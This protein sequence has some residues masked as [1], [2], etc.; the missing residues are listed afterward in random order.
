MALTPHRSALIAGILALSFSAAYSQVFTVGE[1]SATADITT[2]FTPTRVPLPTT[3]LTERGRRELIRNLEA[4]QGFAHRALPVSAGITLQ[5]NGQ[6]TPGPAEYRKLIYEKGQSA[7]PGDRVVI[8]SME[9]KGDRIVL[10]FN[11]GPYAK[12]RFLRHI[13][14]NDA[15]VS[16]GDLG[17]T[18]TGSRITLVF[19]GG[20]PEISG[21]EVKAL[22]QPLIDFGVKSSEQ[23]YADTLPPGLKDAIAAHEVL[24]GMNH[25]MVLAALGAPENKLREQ[26]SSDPNGG[27]Y[28]EWIYG[29]VPQTIRFV[30]F[31]G[32][33]VTLVEIAALGKPIEIHNTNEMGDYEPATPTRDVA[34]GDEQPGKE[35][36][37]PTAPPTLR[38]PGEAAPDGGPGKVQFPDK[39]PVKPIP[40]SPSTNPAITGQGT[41]LGTNPGIG[42]GM[43]PGT[44][45]GMGPGTNPQTNPK[46]PMQ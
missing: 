29:H 36:N 34:M 11:G 23:A 46:P 21:P 45:P 1:K 40:A 12:H 4:E 8:T 26:L 24:V 3:K 15:P 25:R 31:V 16:S 19:E 6:L 28:E 41:G 13:Q 7:A 10:D 30:R 9:I 5:A 22:L 38:L 17:D 18:A 14:L 2:D 39:A 33:R 35:A 20:V 32:D 27:R 43:N 42:P 37:R 44:G